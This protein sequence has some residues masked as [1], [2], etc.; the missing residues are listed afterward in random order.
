VI[1][2]LLTV[3][4]SQHHFQHRIQFA[5]VGFAVQVVIDR[6]TDLETKTQGDKSASCPLLVAQACLTSSSQDE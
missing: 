1:D 6:E 3:A 2:V 5:S 4:D